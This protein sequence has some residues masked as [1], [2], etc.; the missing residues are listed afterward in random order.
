[1]DKM[2]GTKCSSRGCSFGKS[3]TCNGYYRD[4]RMKR[5]MKRSERQAWKKEV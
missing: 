3:C 4:K 5:Q 1:M 2:I